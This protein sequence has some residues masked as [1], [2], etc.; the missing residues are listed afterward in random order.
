[1]K[2]V[3]ALLLG[4]VAVATVAR[5]ADTPSW[6]RYK[7]IIDR[8]PFGQATGNAVVG[9]AAGESS[10]LNRYSF[11]GMI[12][13]TTNPAGRTAIILDKQT[14]RCHFKSPGETLDDIAV[15]RIED[16]QP[17]RRLILRRGLETGALVIGEGARVATVA[18]ATPNQ[19]P[20]MSPGPMPKLAVGPQTPNTRSPGAPPIVRRRIPFQR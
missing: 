20:N 3:A 12:G 5:A 8:N 4:V 2:T 19:P 18:A 1:M 17:K 6:Q 11:V 16:A 14:G 13:S 15:V 7:P 9:V 10:F